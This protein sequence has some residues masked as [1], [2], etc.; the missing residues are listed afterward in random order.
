MAHWIGSGLA[1]L[2][3]SH[4]VVGLTLLFTGVGILVSETTT[5]LQEKIKNSGL[6]KLT[7]KQ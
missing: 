1:A 4:S 3:Q 2:F 6:K 7:Y 5:R